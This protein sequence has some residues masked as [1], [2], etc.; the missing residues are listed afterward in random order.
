MSA[1]DLELHFP[2][3]WSFE[4][5]VD[6]L[7]VDTASGEERSY[8]SLAQGAYM[9]RQTYAG[10]V[11]NM[12][13]SS[14]RQLL[15]SVT[16]DER[17]G[18]LQLVTIGADGG[19]DPMREAVWRMGKAPREPLLAAVS[20]LRRVLSNILQHPDEAK[21]RALKPGNEK[22]RAAC[23]VPGVLALLSLAGFEQ[24]FVD[25]EARLVLPTS[26]PHAPIESA[27]AQMARLEALLTGK[28]L[29]SES[30]AP[31]THAAA[32]ASAAE[33]SHRCQACGKGIANDLRRQLAGSGE[34]GGWRTNTWNGGGEFR[35]HCAKCN[36]DLCS[37]CY[38]QWKAAASGGASGSGGGG[39]SHIHSLACT[40]SI[41]APITTPWGGSSYGVSP[42]PP[43]VTSRNRR[44]PWG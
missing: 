9:T 20:V 16:A 38:D 6:V 7:Y 33:P 14:S 4:G 15:M 39:S 30:L 24:S 43:P 37:A 26:R 29:P 11:W 1:M 18:A 19:L 32:S 31:A 27:A 44:G 34:I 23:D 22:V 8:G 2:N 41:E 28:P 25:G 42:A 40:F 36:V 21:Y 10:H 3:N 17:N 5:T 13:E 35:Y 12:R